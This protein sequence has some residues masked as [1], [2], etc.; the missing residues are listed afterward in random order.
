MGWYRG[1]QI[2][3]NGLILNLDAS[4]KKSYIGSGTTCN[5]LSNNKNRGNLINGVGFNG[6]LTFDGID[7]YVE[8]INKLPIT[9]I[10]T[11]N[12]WVKFNT[13]GTN[14]GGNKRAAIFNHGYNFSAS[15]GFLFLGSG[16]NG[17]DFFISLGHDVKVTVSNQGYI[18]TNKFLFLTAR[19]NAGNELT[20]LYVNG[21]EVTYLVQQDANFAVTYDNSKFSIGASVIPNTSIYE[22]MSNSTIYQVQ[23]YNR[24]LSTTEILQNYN[25]TKS[26]FGY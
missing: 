20:K 13:L 16:N 23:V 2:V 10:F 12:I 3:Q 25:T 19:L 15:K 1:P 6:G 11:I 14:V 5:D 8:I 26:R 24:P 7:D 9:N 21:V 17:T 22:D 4:N 18:S